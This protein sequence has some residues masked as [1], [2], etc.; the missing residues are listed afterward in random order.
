[1]FCFNISTVMGSTP[2][3]ITFLFAAVTQGREGDDVSTR[4]GEGGFGGR[5]GCL[6]SSRFGGRRDM[7]FAEHL[8]THSHSHTTVN[9]SGRGGVRRTKR[10]KKVG[11]RIKPTQPCPQT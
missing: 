10:D 2:I 8:I 11:E 4:E 5:V 9:R 7:L 6:T 1:M 3:W